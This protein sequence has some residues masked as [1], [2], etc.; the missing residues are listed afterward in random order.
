MEQWYKILIY[1]YDPSENLARKGLNVRV[2]YI[3]Q[4]YHYPIY[5]PETS[6]YLD[7]YLN[8]AVHNCFTELKETQITICDAIY[9][10]INVDH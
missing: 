4:L 1:V 3:L 6:W 10:K 2:T 9:T 7:T 5:F 8:D